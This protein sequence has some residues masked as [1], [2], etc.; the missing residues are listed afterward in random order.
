MFVEIVMS[1]WSD[2]DPA[3]WC[4]SD[5]ILIGITDVNYTF[6]SSVCTDTMYY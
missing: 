1:K 4:G 6:Y 5:R 2:T 3:K